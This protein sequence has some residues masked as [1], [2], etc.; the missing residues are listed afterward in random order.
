MFDNSFPACAL[1]VVVVF[2]FF[3]IIVEISTRTL[4]SFFRPGS[5]HSG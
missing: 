5:V 4:I 1:V 2:L 3:F